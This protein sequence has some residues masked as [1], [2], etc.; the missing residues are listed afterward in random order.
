[1]RIESLP[2]EKDLTVGEAARQD[3]RVADAI[4]RT[5][6]RSVPYKTQYRSD[7]SV[8]VY[9]QADMRVFW[10]ELRQ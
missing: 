8:A 2:L 9:L 3:P 7:G 5:V 4:K 10:D 6:A 1:M